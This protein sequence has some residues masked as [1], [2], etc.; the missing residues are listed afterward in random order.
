MIDYEPNYDDYL[1]LE[2]DRY[3]EDFYNGN[4]EDEDEEI[5]ELEEVEKDTFL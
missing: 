4:D 1:N 5:I 2:T 3:L